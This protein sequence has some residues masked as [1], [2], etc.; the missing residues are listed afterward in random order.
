MP[1][2]NKNR[3][4]LFIKSSLGLLRV[5][6]CKLLERVTT[7]ISFFPTAAVVSLTVAGKYEFVVCGL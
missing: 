5:A 6:G 3:N 4:L 2:S 7:L 1:I